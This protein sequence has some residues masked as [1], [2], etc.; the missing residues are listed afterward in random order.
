M[1]K[2][3]EL[4]KNSQE[5]YQRYLNRMTESMK[6]STKGLIPSLVSNAKSILDVGCGSGV[7]LEALEKENKK[8]SLTGLDLNIDA[9]EKLRTLGKEWKLYHMDFMDLTEE[10]YDAIIFSSILHEISSYSKNID[11]R[12]TEMPIFNSLIKANHL[13]EKDGIVI[14]RDGLLVPE[15]NWDR[16]LIISFN[17]SKESAW[18]YRFQNDFR[19][20]DKLNIN[21]EIIEISDNKFMVSEVFLKEFLYTYTWGSESYPREI[22]ERF[23]ILTKEKWGELLKLSGFKIDTVIE[24]PEEY[25]KYLSRQVQIYDQNGKAYVYPSMT[26]TIRAYK[27][28]DLVKSK[29]N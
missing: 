19:G 26:V 9:I 25:E 12:F 6:H 28:K 22:N 7:I 29:A 11:I 23:G 16:K 13:L 20:F 21:K 2:L 14:I 27:E 5:N 18:L 8:A 1:N 17:D 4:S 3:E 15:K 24:S 10:K